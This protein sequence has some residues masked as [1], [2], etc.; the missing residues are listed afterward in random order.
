[1]FLMDKN[2]LLIKTNEKLGLSSI[3][4]LVFEVKIYKIF[5]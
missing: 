3:V 4:K 2:I 5:L 1:M